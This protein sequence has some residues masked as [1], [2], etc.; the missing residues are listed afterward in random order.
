MTEQGHIASPHGVL[1]SAD[2]GTPFALA[3]DDGFEALELRAVLERVAAYAAGPLGHEAILARRP[4]DDVAWISGEL[5]TVAELVH[6]VRDNRGVGAEPVP[7]VDSALSRLRVA[8]SVLE[9]SQLLAIR[10]TLA[11]TPRPGWPE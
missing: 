9:G 10:R 4:S 6:L 8:G 7:E 3:E 2:A 11:T 5:Q 1:V